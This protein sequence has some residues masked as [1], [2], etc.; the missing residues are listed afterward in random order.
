MP[1]IKLSWYSPFDHRPAI[2]NINRVWKHQTIRIPRKRTSLLALRFRL[3]YIGICASKRSY[4]VFCS[5]AFQRAVS[6]PFTGVS[7]SEGLALRLAGYYEGLHGKLGAGAH[8]KDR[9]L[10]AFACIY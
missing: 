3:L 2:T 1:I 7:S 9:H 8:S 6:D 10:V 5:L 4:T